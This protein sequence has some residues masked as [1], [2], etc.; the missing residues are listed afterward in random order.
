[1]LWIY[2]TEINRAY[3]YNFSVY[4][5]STIWLHDQLLNLPLMGMWVIFSVLILKQ[6][7]VV[8]MNLLSRALLLMPL[9]FDTPHSQVFPL[10]FTHSRVGNWIASAWVECQHWINCVWWKGPTVHQSYSHS[11]RNPCDWEAHPWGI[12]SAGCSPWGQLLMSQSPALN[13][14]PGTE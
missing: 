10:Q 11:K 12:C 4:I 2:T 9:C 13:T 5:Y 3:H 14:V 8:C 7:Y 1:M 6:W